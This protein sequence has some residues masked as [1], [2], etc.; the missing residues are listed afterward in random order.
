M[1]LDTEIEIGF[2]DILIIVHRL[3]VSEVTQTGIQWPMVRVECAVADLRI[4]GT[5]HIA[6]QLR[7]H[8]LYKSDS[9]VGQVLE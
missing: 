9:G 2:Q 8:H 5:I 7:L 3:I 1:V 6:F 4:L